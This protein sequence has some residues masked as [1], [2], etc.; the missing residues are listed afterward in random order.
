MFPALM[1][2]Y[3]CCNTEM[4][5]SKSGVNSMDTSCLVSVVQSASRGVM[6]GGYFLGILCVFLT[7][8]LWEKCCCPPI[9]KVG[10]HE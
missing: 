10:W 8:H 5:G 2:L 7:E 1:S 6:V 4:A 3:F 9:S